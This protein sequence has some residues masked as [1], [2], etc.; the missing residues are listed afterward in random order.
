MPF[1]LQGAPLLVSRRWCLCTTLSLINAAGSLVFVSKGDCLEVMDGSTG[2]ERSG[3]RNCGGSG[4]IICKYVWYLCIPFLLLFLYISYG[5]FGCNSNLKLL[6]FWQNSLLYILLCIWVGLEMEITL[7]DP[8]TVIFR[9]TGDWHRHLEK[10][11][12][13][14]FHLIVNIRSHLFY[15]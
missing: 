8:T 2:K 10:R 13:S 3:C 14:A 5:V 15:T 7:D 12:K 4:A 1:P 6:S 9:G 11:L